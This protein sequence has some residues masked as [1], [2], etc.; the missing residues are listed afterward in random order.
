MNGL[1]VES[2]LTSLKY[3]L[4]DWLKLFKENTVRKNTFI[5]HERNIAKH[6][7]PYFKNI[8]LKEIK[9]MMYQ[10]FINHLTDKGYSKRTIEIIHG[11]MHNAMKKAVSLKKIEYNPCED[12][13]ISNKNNKEKECL[14]YMRTEDI[15]LFLKNTYQYNY[16]YYIFFKTLINTGMRKGEAA[17]LQWSDIDF[18]EQTIN[19][20]KTLD[21]SAKK[22]ENLFGDTKTFTSR[23]TILI[24]KLLVNDLLNHK[25]W[26]NEN[27]LVLQEAYKHELDL[28]FTKVDG[29]FLPKS[30][31][32][33]AFSRILKK[34]DLPKLEIHSLRHTHAVLLL[35]S[36]ASMKYIQDRL[37]H[38]NI[39]ITSNVYSHISDKINKDSIA[40]FE[41]Y[42]NDVLG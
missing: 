3:Y 17:A 22:G 35:E 12:I 11:T 38:K 20:T 15:P 2:T 23:R 18:K 39:E 25:K 13:V 9:P 40:E 28:V 29:S 8:N 24:P 27:K 42:M 32:F 16:I 36:G 4:R 33:N 10:N 14:K 30:T 1:E 21:F 41:A 37:G 34:A 31:L 19:I 26:Q 7:I 5:L 6:L